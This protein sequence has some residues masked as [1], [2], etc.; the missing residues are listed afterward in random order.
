MNIIHKKF[1]SDSLDG[2]WV[3]TI[4][5]FDGYHLGHQKLV[6]QVL[7]DSKKLNIKGGVLTF[8]PHPKKV[9][10]SQIPFRHIYDLPSKCTFIEESGLDACFI[11]PFTAKF[12]KMGSHEFLEKLFNFVNL[13]KIVVGYDFN[14]GKAREGSASL[15]KQEAIKNNI[16]FLR[17]EAVKIEGLTVSS[18]M[19]RRLLFEGDFEKVNQYLGRSWSVSGVVK[20]GKKLGHT[21]GFPTIN[22]EPGV[23]LPLRKGVYTCQIQLENRRIKGV[24][25]VGYNPTFAGTDLKVEAHLFD[26]NENIYGEF[27]HITPEKFLRD[28]TKF[29]SIEDLKSQIRKDVKIAKA[30]FRNKRA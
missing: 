30:Y 19:I 18:T 28:E 22:L 7:K 6:Q 27:V 10:Q 8:E 3:I 21:L 1:K 11:I 5:N 16:D 29:G 20:E 4:G 17:M 14:F 26:F 12:A 25:N 2:D 9:L 15:M 23:L 13:K 24:C